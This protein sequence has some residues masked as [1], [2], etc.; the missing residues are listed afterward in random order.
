MSILNS[1]QSG[2]L[3]EARKMAGHKSAETTRLYDRNI[4]SVDPEEVLRIK[5]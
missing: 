2:Q 3:E 5:Y 4:D 1:P